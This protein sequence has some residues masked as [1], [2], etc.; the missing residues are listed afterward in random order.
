MD[1]NMNNEM[2]LRIYAEDHIRARLLEAENYQML[3][4]LRSHYHVDISLRLHSLLRRLG[5][6]LIALGRGL[7]AIKPA[8]QHDL[9]AK[10][11]L[12]EYP[13]IVS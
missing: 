13:K 9:K 7:K 5:H 8:W 10:V 3:N 11:G 2:Q 6:S 12:A 1:M 4:Q